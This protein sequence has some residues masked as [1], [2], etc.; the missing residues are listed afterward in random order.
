MPWVSW[1]RYHSCICT[2]IAVAPELEC[3]HMCVCARLRCLFDNICANSKCEVTTDTFSGEVEST[4]EGISHF[5][6]IHTQAPQIETNN[7]MTT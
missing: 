1:E 5:T 2:Y 7:P 4:R 6:R 3:C